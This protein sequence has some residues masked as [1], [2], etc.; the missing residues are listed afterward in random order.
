MPVQD[1]DD[2]LEKE[3][4]IQQYLANMSEEEKNQL[5]QDK[6]REC[7]EDHIRVVELQGVQ[8]FLGR[9]NGHDLCAGDFE[10]KRK[11]FARVRFVFNHQHAYSLEGP[12]HRLGFCQVELISVARHTLF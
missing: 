2:R 6:I 5:I 10:R 1:E 11:K 8:R 4:A 7:E 3:E 12:S 9:L